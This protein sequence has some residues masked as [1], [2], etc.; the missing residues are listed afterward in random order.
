MAGVSFSMPHNNIEWI[1][2]SGANQHFTTS[3][4]NL[5]DVVDISDLNLKVDH[6][7]GSS[8][9]ILKIGFQSP[10]NST[11]LAFSTSCKVIS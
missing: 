11:M 6:P 8:A 9:K 1:I 4:T 7:N 5:S 10:K 3:D 2:D